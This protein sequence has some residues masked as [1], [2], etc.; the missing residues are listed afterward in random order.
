M[1]RARVP[2]LRRTPGTSFQPPALG[3]GL[4]KPPSVPQPL[5]G[6]ESQTQGTKLRLFRRSGGCETSP[7]PSRRLPRSGGLFTFWQKKPP[8]PNLVSPAARGKWW[9]LLGGAEAPG[10]PHKGSETGQGKIWR[11]WKDLR[12]LGEDLGAWGE[13]LS[14]SSLLCGVFTPGI[15]SLE[16]RRAAEGLFPNQPRPARSGGAP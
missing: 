8:R 7:N 16:S 13:A 10:A 6:P 11:C 3:R 1:A 9:E 5:Q 15:I 4:T 14:G 2:E 12:G